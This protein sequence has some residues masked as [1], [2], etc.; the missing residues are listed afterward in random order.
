MGVLV[1]GVKVKVKG[2]GRNAPERSGT[3]PIDRSA[4]GTKNTSGLELRTRMC[5][6]A[7]VNYRAARMGTAAD[8]ID[9]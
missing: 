5:T 8:R 9:T 2:Q 3:I 4:L 6:P 1:L 7:G